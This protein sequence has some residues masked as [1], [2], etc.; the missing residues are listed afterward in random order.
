MASRGKMA[1]ASHWASMGGQGGLRELACRGGKGALVFAEFKVHGGVSSFL[2]WWTGGGQVDQSPG[3]GGASPWCQ[4]SPCW[5]AW[6][7]SVCCVRQSCKRWGQS[8]L[9]SSLAW[10]ALQVLVRW[11]LQARRSLRRAGRS[12][13]DRA[14]YHIA[15]QDVLRAV[16]LLK[17]LHGAGIA[18]WRCRWHRAHRPRRLGPHGGAVEQPRPPAGRRRPG[19]G[20][21]SS[22][23]QSSQSFGSKLASS[24]ICTSAASYALRRPY[25]RL[26]VVF[27]PWLVV[28]SSNQRA[29][30]VLVWV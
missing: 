12:W 2:G 29:V 1:S 21:R 30:T 18:G 25:F 3:S 23:L 24:P 10:R 14:R 16:G 11:R 15:I 4:C 20:R 22:C 13:A 28:E 26:M 19:R 27:T 7:A 17:A 6:R 5:V 9:P 8:A